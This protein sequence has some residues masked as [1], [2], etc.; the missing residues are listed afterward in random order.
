MMGSPVNHTEIR[1]VGFNAWGPGCKK[2]DGARQDI[3][4]NL[5]QHAV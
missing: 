3:S 5:L 1:D 4:A 2:D